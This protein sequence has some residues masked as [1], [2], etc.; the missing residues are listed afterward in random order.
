MSGRR[1][2]GVAGLAV[3]LGGAAGMAEPPLRDVAWKRLEFGASKLLLAATTAVQV[4]RVPVA[5]AGPGLRQPPE[6]SALAA[7]GPELVLLTLDSE[8]PFGR[9]EH[10]TVWLEPGSGAALQG[11]KLVTGRKPYEKVFRYT[12][13]GFYS[14]RAAPAG[15]SEES[16]GPEA[17]S[18]RRGKLVRASPRPPAGAVVTDSYALLY[19][20]SAARLDRPG[21]ELRVLVLAEERPVELQ[22]LAGG[23]VQSRLDYREQGSDGSRRRSQDVLQRVVTVSGRPLGGGSAAGEV[24]LGFLGLRGAV[25]LFLDASTGLPV[26]LQG[27]ADKIGD[28]VVTL[29]GVEWAGPFL[30]GPGRGEGGGS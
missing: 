14:W 20:A 28:L 17:W 18:R 6:G 4:E 11:Y 25:R 16:L 22:F 5:R 12:T 30:A 19:L 21:A 24:D 26:R 15:D 2:A 29:K 1:H 7:A 27:R 9:R 13:E 23:L 3:L 10:T 8:L